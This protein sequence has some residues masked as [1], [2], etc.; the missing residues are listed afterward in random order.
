MTMQLR[1]A[2]P[3]FLRAPGRC[4]PV[5]RNKWRSLHDDTT[6]IKSYNVTKCRHVPLRQFDFTKKIFKAT[7]GAG[8]TLITLGLRNFAPWQASMFRRIRNKDRFPYAVL[9]D[10]A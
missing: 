5:N 8:S 2:T 1:L 10:P 9:K 3:D 4:P 6:Q 7:E